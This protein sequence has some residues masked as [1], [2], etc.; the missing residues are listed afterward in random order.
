M[1]KPRKELEKVSKIPR[2]LEKT[3]ITAK[4]RFATSMGLEFS[5]VSLEEVVGAPGGVEKYQKMTVAE[6]AKEFEDL[7][8]QQARKPRFFPIL[9]PRQTQ[10]AGMMTDVQA[11]SPSMY[12]QVSRGLS[13]RTR[14]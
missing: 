10:Q 6:A 5:E 13:P 11:G 14:G 2:Q 12:H 8:V 4:H 9:K 1:A 7:K 3:Q